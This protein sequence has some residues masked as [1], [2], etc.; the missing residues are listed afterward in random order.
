M[1]SKSAF[2][3]S[4]VTNEPANHGAYDFIPANTNLVGYLVEESNNLVPAPPKRVFAY[5][6]LDE[7]N[8]ALRRLSNGWRGNLIFQNKFI[9]WTHN[10][11]ADGTENC[12]IQGTGGEWYDF[13]IRRI[14][15]DEYCALRLELRKPG[16]E[17]MYHP[18]AE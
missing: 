6:T 16:F 3:F 11:R 8:N 10:M 14:T 1:Y 17:I 2:P 18:W 9:S 7:A 13:S 5:Q 4:S 15:D 12:R